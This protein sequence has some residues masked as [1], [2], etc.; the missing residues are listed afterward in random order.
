MIYN[1]TYF[2]EKHGNEE[3]AHSI[4]VN[5]HALHSILIDILLGRYHKNDM[6]LHF[7]LWTL[8]QIG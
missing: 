2:V 1:L 3:V 4:I 6:T 7:K 8:T 5:I